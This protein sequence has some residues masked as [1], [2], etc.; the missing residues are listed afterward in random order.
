[1]WRDSRRRQPRCEQA[2]CSTD[3]IVCNSP[4]ARMIMRSHL[5]LPSQPQSNADCHQRKTQQNVRIQRR[6]LAAAAAAALEIKLARASVAQRVDRH[7]AM[8]TMHLQPVGLHALPIPTKDRAAVTRLV[9][10][11][12]CFHL[13][14]ERV[15]D[16]GAAR[17]T[18]DPAQDR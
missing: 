9:R 12:G 13:A 8:A 14:T 3:I 10:V 6:T 7:V 16:V 1:M 18:Q 2:S 15:V 4:I 11:A 5:A 17:H